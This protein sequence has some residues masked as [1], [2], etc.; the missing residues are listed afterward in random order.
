MPGKS[1]CELK[2]TEFASCV[3][4]CWVLFSGID[5]LHFLTTLFQFSAVLWPLHV[6]QQKHPLNFVFLGLFTLS[7]SVTVGVAVANTEG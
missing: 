6:Y 2:S 7:L 4:H 3:V 1:R 5:L